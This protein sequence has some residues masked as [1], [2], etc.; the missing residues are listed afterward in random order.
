MNEAQNKKWFQSCD[1][2][3][4]YWIKFSLQNSVDHRLP[5][6]M[7]ERS[8]WMVEGVD[9]LYEKCLQTRRKQL[10]EFS[11]MSTPS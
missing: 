10:Q 7:G 9:G 6:D 2:L 1:Y 8:L 5:C 3:R 11:K 4:K